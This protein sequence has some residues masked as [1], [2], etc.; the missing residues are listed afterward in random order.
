MHAGLTEEALSGYLELYVRALSDSRSV[1]QICRDLAES[2]VHLS[3][4]VVAD[5]AEK[6]FENSILWDCPV[7][8]AMAD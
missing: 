5:L 7:L 6:P 8:R 1:D 2:G 4:K 3:E